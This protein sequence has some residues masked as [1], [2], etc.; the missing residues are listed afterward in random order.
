MTDIQ[1]EDESYDAVITSHVLE[2]IPKDVQAISE[3][4]RIIS[5]GGWALI[6]V[7]ITSEKTLED[8]TLDA[9]GRKKNYGLEDHFRAYGLDIASKLKDAGFEVEIVSFDDVPGNWLDRNAESPHVD[10]DKY[11]FYC[12]KP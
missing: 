9:V 7:P 1:F 12:R 3:L 11:L 5:H 2:H 8:K 10:S 6:A 4:F